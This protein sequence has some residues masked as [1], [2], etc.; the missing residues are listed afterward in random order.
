MIKRIGGAKA[1]RPYLN[2]LKSIFNIIQN[3]FKSEKLLRVTALLGILVFPLLG[4]LVFLIKFVLRESLSLDILKTVS[5]CY[6][7]FSVFLLVWCFITTKTDSFLLTFLRALFQY[8]L[9]QFLLSLCIK[10]ELCFQ[11]PFVAIRMI[12]Y[13]F[14]CVVWFCFFYSLGHASIL[15]LS[16]TQALFSISN[17][18][19]RFRR[20]FFNAACLNVP[21][22]KT[23]T[24]EEAIQLFD[25]MI[26]G[27][28]FCTN[29]VLNG[30]LA[31][32]DKRS[33]KQASLRSLLSPHTNSLALPFL[34]KQ[35]GSVSSSTAA[36]AK[37]AARHAEQVLA[38]NP[39]TVAASTGAIGGVG[40]LATE[41]YETSRTIASNE[42]IAAEA[43][44]SVELE[45]ARNR[46]QEYDKDIASYNKIINETFFLLRE[47]DSLKAIKAHKEEIVKERDENAQ[48]VANLSIPE[49]NLQQATLN[50]PA[51]SLPSESKSAGWIDRVNE[52]LCP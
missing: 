29:I 33:K 27:E 15:L 22:E 41:H 1:Q 40:Y 32:V 8:S 7:F 23:P 48:K 28:M 36:V 37:S 31:S 42:R 47:P 3:I 51:S 19:I 45:N 17:I 13:C 30:V 16:C 11:S 39:G 9:P 46:T 10:A 26:E 44:R 5:F 50:S 35:M 25:H 43:R 52:W 20:N 38:Q 21:A 24:F 6:C 14:C 34:S 2:Y 4:F 18:Y 49:T 12:L